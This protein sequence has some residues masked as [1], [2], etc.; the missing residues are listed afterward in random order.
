MGCLVPRFAPPAPLVAFARRRL[1]SISLSS[2]SLEDTGGFAF[3][4][5]RSGDESESDEGAL[6]RL[7][8]LEGLEGIGDDDE[9]GL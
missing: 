6:A 9:A 5:G 1:R 8:G 3:F 7:S 2:A 4:T